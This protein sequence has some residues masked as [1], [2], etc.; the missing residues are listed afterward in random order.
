MKL[1]ETT[2]VSWIVVASGRQ[3]SAVDVLDSRRVQDKLDSG[4]VLVL[5]GGAEYGNVITGLTPG[6]Q[7]VAV[8][9]AKDSSLNF[10]YLTGTMPTST[11]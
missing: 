10:G 5:Q 6:S 9:I 3:V 1:T 7:Y 8:A 11:S 2:T 4:I